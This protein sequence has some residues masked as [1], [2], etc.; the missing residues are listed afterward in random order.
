MNSEDRRKARYLRRK[1]K[2]YEKREKRFGAFDDFDNV[3]TFDHLWES[4][5]KCLRGVGWKTSVQKHR[6]RPI[7]N[8]A[9]LYIQLHN[10]TYKSKGFYLFTIVERGKLRHIKSVHISERVVQRCLCDYSLVPILSASMI[11]DNGACIKGKGI[12]FAKDRLNCHLQRYFREHKSN[13]GYALVIDYSSFFDRILHD[14][15]KEIIRRYYSDERII[16][17]YEHFIDM[18]GEIGLGLG[19]QVSQ[20]SAL[21]YP[22]ALDQSVKSDLH[23]KYYARYSD[24]SYLIH[25]SKDY[26]HFCKR[27]I[28]EFCA[29]YGIKLNPKKTQIVKL[30]RGIPFLKHRFVL[31]D[32]GEV[33]RLPNEESEKRMRGKIRV[34]ARWLVEGIITF[35]AI[36]NSNV[37]WASHLLKSNAHHKL[38]NM[39]KYYTEK[40]IKGAL[41]KWQLLN[42]TPTSTK[43]ETNTSIL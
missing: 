20:I 22:G 30:S 33:L 8:V 21:R 9:T 1:A 13:E 14:K 43:K 27:K 39:Q 24:D 18:F 37:S 25:E 19:S 35:E 42:S 36:E 4:H 41:Q 12:D 32:T 23:V 7:T 10:G 28:E 40:I 11:Y 31:L 2:R 6:N 15:L 5:K 17:L 26:L 3:F 34:F 38:R 16:R 29:E